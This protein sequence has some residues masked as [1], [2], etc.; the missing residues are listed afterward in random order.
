MDS[1]N[2]Y[3]II[4]LIIKVVQQPLCLCLSVC[5]PVSLSLFP[6]LSLPLL[7]PSPSVCVFPS[8]PPPPFSLTHTHTHT[9]TYTRASTPSFLYTV[10]RSLR[11]QCLVPC[12][13]ACGALLCPSWSVPLHKVCLNVFFISCACTQYRQLHGLAAIITCMTD[14]V[15][16]MM[17]D[18]LSLCFI[19]D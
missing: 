13:H 15:C 16:S 8:P 2:F 4:E 6:S 10:Q 7:S 12:M 14:G 17:P 18:Y 11:K 5:L 9:C 3:W 19:I 1:N